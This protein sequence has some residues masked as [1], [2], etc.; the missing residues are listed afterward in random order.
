M[1]PVARETAYRFAA[2][3]ACGNRGLALKQITPFFEQYQPGIPTPRQGALPRK[4]EHFVSCVLAMSP[5]SQRYALYDLCD[6]PPSMRGSQPSLDTRR[7]LRRTLVQADGV[8][9]LAVELSAISVAGVR[10]RWFTAASRLESSPAAALTAARTLLEATCKTLLVELGVEP[11]MSGEIG[12]LVKQAARELGLTASDVNSGSI[13]KIWGGLTTIVNGLAS[14]SNAA[15][16]RHG[17]V[18]GTGLDDPRIAGLAVHA[19]GTLTLFLVHVARCP[20]AG[21]QPSPDESC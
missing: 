20:F 5:P 18:A 13:R 7:R 6:W 9:P 11:D 2:E 14:A 16:D 15:G 1:R 19:A 10:D 8:S 3:Y 4:D 12:R 17:V 21:E